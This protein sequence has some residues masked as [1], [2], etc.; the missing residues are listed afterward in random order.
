MRKRR[1]SQQRRIGAAVGVGDGLRQQR[2]GAGADLPQLNADAV[3]RPAGYRVEDMG[4][5]TPVGLGLAR[6]V[7]RIDK[8]EPRDQADL[9]EGGGA[10]RVR[11]VAEA[12]LEPVED[13]VARVPAHA[14][15]E[16]EAEALAVGG[17]EPLEAGKFRIA[18]AVEAEAALL[19]LRRCGQGVGAGHLARQ[20][21]DGRG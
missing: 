14:D 5:E 7:H 2:L 4:G 20:A 12:A 6:P 11:V 9:G 8:A 10:L 17:V 15:D 21:R 19:L 3:G 16:R 1:A 13:G 18:Q